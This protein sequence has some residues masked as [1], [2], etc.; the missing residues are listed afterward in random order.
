MFGTAL[1]DAVGPALLI[2]WSVVGPWMLRQIYA[3]CS[4][5]APTRPEPRAATGLTPMLPRDLL[6][7]ARE[8][9]AGEPRGNQQDY[10]AG[11]PSGSDADRSRSGGAIV[12]VVRVEMAAA[13][14]KARPPRA[15]RRHPRVRPQQRPA[16]RYAFG[17]VLCHP[18]VLGLLRGR[19]YRR[20]CAAP[21]ERR[22]RTKDLEPQVIIIAATTRIY[23]IPIVE[24]L[25]RPS[26]DRY[27]C[28][29]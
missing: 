24:S 23:Q 18:I 17:P 16:S 14:V 9:D 25:S 20:R 19:E 7:R 21:P 27:T 5:T 28:P 13:E 2:G 10:L 22:P 6:A 3:V 29:S 15:A 12:A 1:V 11:R 4:P 8:L 26:R